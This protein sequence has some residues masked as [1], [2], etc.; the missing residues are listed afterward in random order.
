MSGLSLYN[1]ESALLDL[2][3]AREELMAQRGD[4]AQQQDWED[5]DEQTV[6]VE[7]ALEEYVRAEVKKC[8]GIHWYLTAAKQT[9]QDARAEARRMDERARRIENSA[10]RLKAICC[11]V[12][13]MAEV[14]RIDGTAGR[15]LLRKGNGG[16]APLVVDG[17]DAERERWATD[18]PVL[19]P[20]FQ[21][22]TI[23]MP[24][25]LWDYAVDGVPEDSELGK[26]LRGVRNIKTGPAN[27][28]IR[29]ALAAGEEVPGAR[30]D[31]RGEHLEIK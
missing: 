2:L 11:D 26:D 24:R 29:A 8:D 3:T 9:A 15:Y 28:R 4:L 23:K 20:I 31:Q 21:D 10:D 22:V 19:P 5:I 17:W 7:K 16:L 12:M 30:L 1:I 14:K 13:R 18:A 27:D 25:W 6:A